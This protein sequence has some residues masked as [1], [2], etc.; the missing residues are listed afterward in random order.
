MSNYRYRLTRMHQRL[1]ELI[2]L[3]RERRLP[4]WFRLLRLKRLRLAVKDRLAGLHRRPARAA[5]AG[6]R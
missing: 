2:R 6:P 1:D 4:D 5:S 3:E